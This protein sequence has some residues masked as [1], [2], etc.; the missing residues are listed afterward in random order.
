MSA[1][2]PT[3]ASNPDSPRSASA[4]LAGASASLVAI[5]L[6]RFAYTPLIPPMIQAHW[7]AASEVAYLGAANLAGYLIGALSGRAMGR[8]AHPVWMLRLMMLLASISFIAC[9]FPLSDVWF[10]CWRLLSG[11][12]GGVT[13]VLVSGVVLPTVPVH[14]RGLAS[15][16]IFLGIGVGVVFSGTVVPV[17][18]QTSLRATWITIGIAASILTAATWRAW[19]PARRTP[20]PSTLPRPG[21]RRM[22]PESRRLLAQYGLLAA[23]L[24]PGMMFLVDYVARA[25]GKGSSIGALAWVAY[26]VGAMAGPVLYGLLA[27]HCGA[28]WAIRLALALQVGCA[29]ALTLVSDTA[30]LVGLSLLLGSFPAG[31]VPATIARVHELVHDH[32]ARETMWTRATVAFAVVQA[33]SGYVYSAVYDLSG[34]RHVLLFGLGGLA[35]LLSLA[36]DALPSRGP[37]ASSEL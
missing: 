34:G 24:V 14:R 28:R 5:G 10:F 19:P 27:D 18:L 33:I 36:I 25:L 30:A 6:A 37:R 21:L 31:I 12:A 1:T 8:Y 23:G 7:F 17:T 20:E 4:I 11:V 29:A 3:H 2:H 32:H 35:F 15:G 9:A 13:M 16:A 26:G 22:P